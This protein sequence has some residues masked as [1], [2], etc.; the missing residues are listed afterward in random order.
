MWKCEKFINEFYY[1]I[2]KQ[3]SASSWQWE[4]KRI[5]GVKAKAEGWELKSDEASWKLEVG[6][7]NWVRMRTSICI[8]I[9]AVKEQR[10]G[11]ARA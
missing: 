3:M 2:K 7:M 8:C 1:F 6:G 4:W 10:Q 9:Y 11:A 5:R